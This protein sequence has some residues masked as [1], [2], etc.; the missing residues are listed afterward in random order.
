MADHNAGRWAT[1]VAAERLH[2]A[3]EVGVKGKRFDVYFLLE[4]LVQRAQLFQDC[5][6]ILAT[7]NKEPPEAVSLEGGEK[8]GLEGLVYELFEDDSGTSCNEGNAAL[9]RHG[10][11]E[12]VIANERTVS[13]PGR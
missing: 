9:S 6:V 8:P 11:A 7:L 13:W 10:V 5:V 3:L 1:G 2:S 4:S 12:N